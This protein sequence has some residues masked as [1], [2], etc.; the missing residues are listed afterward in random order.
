MA[1]VGDDRQMREMLDRRNR[2]DVECVARVRLVGADAALAE[3][4]IGV[5]LIHD[6]LCRIQPLVNRRRKPSLEH[7]GLARTPDRTQEAKVLHIACANLE[8]VGIGGDRIH[9]L[10]HRDLGHN[11][12]PCL[13]AC[14]GEV[15][16]PLLLKP[17]ECVGRGAR[18]VRAAADEL[19]AARFDDLRRRE[20]L[21]TRLD[22]AG[23]RHDHRIPV[24]DLYA[25]HVDDRRCGM[26]FAARELVALGDGDG[27]LNAVHRIQRSRRE[28]C[29]VADHADDLLPRALHDLRLKPL[30][31]NG[32]DDVF[33]ILLRGIRVHNNNHLY[34]SLLFIACRVY[35]ENTEYLQPDALL[36]DGIDGVAYG[37][38]IAM[39]VEIEKEQ[40]R[41]EL[42]PRG[43]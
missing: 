24:A 12:E 7:D 40:I 29:L 34:R 3:D 30:L 5:P 26:E 14:L 22:G 13:F 21:F 33:N 20:Q 15:F 16:Q 41:A 37:I 39:R 36:C 23:A 4:D 9:G 17:L 11:G 10:D 25:A 27:R 42:R 6:V 8:N 1:R 31:L 35:G 18:L 38:R 19:C 2:T 43:A 28:L 32:A